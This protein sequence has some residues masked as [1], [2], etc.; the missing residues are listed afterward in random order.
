MGSILLIAKDYDKDYVK[1]ENSDKGAHGLNAA[2]RCVGL[3]ALVH[4]HSKT[5]TIAQH[6]T[7]PEDRR[8]CV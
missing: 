8:I 4:K 3:I 7:P 6:N 2:Y 1:D 5:I